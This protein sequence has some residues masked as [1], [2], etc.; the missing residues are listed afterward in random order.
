LVSPVPGER[1]GTLVA[2]LAGPTTLVAVWATADAA[3]AKRD[4]SDVVPVFEAFKTG[5]WA[6]LR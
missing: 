2:R 3:S 4:I 1:V 5:V 6:V